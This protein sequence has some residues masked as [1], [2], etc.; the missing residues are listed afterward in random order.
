[1]AKSGPL[2]DI[3]RDDV[4]DF[5]RTCSAMSHMGMVEGEQMAIFTVIAGI[6]HLGDV[7]FSDDP[8]DKKGRNS[9]RYSNISC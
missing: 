1:M 5:E 6:L 3:L 2:T 4:K 7:T 9:F 8:S